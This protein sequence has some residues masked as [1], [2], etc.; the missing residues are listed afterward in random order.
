M[1][2]F[3]KYVIQCLLVQSVPFKVDLN[4]TDKWILFLTYYQR[5]E[6]SGLK[7][8]KFGTYSVGTLVFCEK[9][10]ILS[11]NCA[12]DCSFGE[13]EEKAKGDQRKIF[14][15]DWKIY[16]KFGKIGTFK[17]G[18]IEPTYDQNNNQIKFPN[19][20]AKKIESVFPENSVLW[21]SLN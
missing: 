6:F 12:F 4:L 16:S 7:S 15:G 2:T 18:F 9:V 1:S 5:T 13:M 21:S 8:T 14:S 17:F 11:V 3:H 19:I 10:C 20:R